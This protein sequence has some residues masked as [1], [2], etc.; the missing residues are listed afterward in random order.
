MI[1]RIDEF[2]RKELWLELNPELSITDI[3]MRGMDEGVARVGEEEIER[4]L[5]GLVREGYFM[6]PKAVGADECRALAVA[7]E[8]LVE[9]G[10]PTPFL[11]VYDETWQLFARA[12]APIAGLVGPDFLAGGDLWVWHVA[13]EP[14]GAGWGPHRDAN[15]GDELLPDG[16]PQV[17]T[18]WFA[19]TEATPENGCMY[20]LP[21]DRDP[22][23]PEALGDKSVALADLASVRALPAQPG[24][25]MGWNTRL[26]HWGARSS[27]R[28]GAPRISVSMYVQRRD[29]ERLTADMVD[30]FASVPLHHRLGVVSRAL[31]TYAES[32]LSGTTVP[33]PMLAFATEQ[34]ARL[35][36]WLAMT[37]ELREAAAGRTPRM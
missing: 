27:A 34:R 25:L 19:L 20:V 30:P 6:F 5:E 21:T 26:L 29:A 23:V 32:G 3:P 22:N 24:A 12:A 16:R 36:K 35:I 1:A 7:V 14:G 2:D 33:E 4:Q 11:W 10:I 37:I 9:A 8:R 31:L 18:V 15:L 28:A 17:V 13:P